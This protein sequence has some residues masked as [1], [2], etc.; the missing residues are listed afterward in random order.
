VMTGEILG[1]RFRAQAKR[2]K[3]VDLDLWSLSDFGKTFF[4][5]K[6]CPRPILK[7]LL[8]SDIL[9]VVSFPFSMHLDD[10]STKPA[11]SI[12][13]WIMVLTTNVATL[14]QCFNSCR[15][16]EVLNLID[17]WHWQCVRDME[18]ASLRFVSQLLPYPWYFA[19]NKL[20]TRFMD[21][22]STTCEISHAI[23]LFS[24]LNTL[25]LYKLHCKRV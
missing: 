7:W 25:M 11:R 14:L 9:L 1:S 18:D 21:K 22:R 16:W 6:G 3:S 13:F 12:V 19:T 24:S 10:R 20:Y 23:L 4:K 15:Y 8:H 17:I 5:K 2:R